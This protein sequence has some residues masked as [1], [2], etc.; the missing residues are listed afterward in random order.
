VY[1]YAINFP[2][3]PLKNQSANNVIE[4]VKVNGLQT[5]CEKLM[6]FGLKN[7]PPKFQPQFEK[8]MLE[9]L[10]YDIMICHRIRPADKIMKHLFLFG[11]KIPIM[12]EF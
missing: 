12:S 6:I 2:P 7:S 8:K 11:A 5:L 4:R 9:V 3:L 10:L 1:Q